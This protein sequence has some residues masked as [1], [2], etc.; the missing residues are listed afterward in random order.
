MIPPI[1]PSGSRKVMFTY[2]P[3]TGIVV[4]LDLGGHAGEIFERIDR[5]DRIDG[6]RIADRLSGVERLQLGELGAVGFQPAARASSEASRARAGPPPPA[7]ECGKPRAY[8]GI[9]I[10]LVAFGEMSDDLAVAGIVG[11]ER[12]AAGRRTE[13]AIDERPPGFRLEF[14]CGLHLRFVHFHLQS[15]SSVRSHPAQ[16]RST[17]VLSTSVRNAS[18]S[19]LRRRS[20]R[21]HFLRGLHLEAGIGLD[22]FDRHARKQH[23][24][25]RFE[26]VR[27]RSRRCI[28]AS[29]SIFGPPP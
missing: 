19:S 22:V 24:K 2:G 12:L 23:G 5:G 17:P 11:R 4:A 26:R 18:S 29:R 20:N 8:R 27:D 13:L 28:S 21:F 15:L 14:C 6:A 1:T 16:W 9:D 3:G 25:P 10:L 7:R